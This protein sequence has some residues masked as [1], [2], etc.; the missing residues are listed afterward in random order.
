MRRNNAKSMLRVGIAALALAA[1]ASCGSVK[2]K[3]ASSDYN[4]ALLSFSDG[5]TVEHNTLSDIY[6]AIVTEGDTNSEKVLN[7]VLYLYSKSLYGPYFDETASDGTTVKGIKSIADAYL[8]NSAATSDIDAFASAYDVYQPTDDKLTTDN[9]TLAA[10]ARTNVISF[11]NEVTFRINTVF[12]GYVTDTNYQER[13]QFQEKK[14]YD[15]QV[16]NYYVLGSQYK[17]DYVQVDGSFRLTGEA[18]ADNVLMQR[19]FADLFGTY[20]DYIAINVLPDIYRNELT[21]QYLYSQNFGTLRMTSARKVDYIEL[22]NNGDYS[23]AVPNLMQ[24][25][26]KEVIVP[27]K[28]KDFG[29]PFLNALYKGTAESYI[30]GLT[31]VTAKAEAQTLANAIY[32]DA[33]WT[34]T[35]ATV[36]GVTYNTY[37]QSSLGTIVASYNKLTDSRF[38]DDATVRSNFTNSGAYS[39][40][41]GFYVQYQAL[42]AKDATKNGWF[43]AGGLSSLPSSLSDRAFLV[44]VANEVD[45]VTDDDIHKLQYGWYVGGSYYLTPATYPSGSA[46][47]YLVNDGTNYFLVRVDEAVKAAKITAPA[48]SGSNAL[49]YDLTKGYGYAQSIARKMA[50]ALSSSDTWKK[51]AK[52]YY[53]DQIALIYHDSY[54]YDDFEKT[55]PERFD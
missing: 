29:F 32:A 10:E 48:T 39:V 23:D 55:L 13:S 7:N 4:A 33:G 27:G 14:F 54:V 51:A 15:A 8:A 45:S 40:E 19:Y 21:A 18:V 1:L 25:Y 22:A 11:Y 49:Y 44:Q 50:Y 43:T 16:K 47:P 42:L 35:S 38:T 20:G 41:T 17:S 52:T 26:C 6:D 5:S 31:D 24:A 2:A 12:Y 30:N 36:N 9:A 34:A 53:V 46:Y 37:I 3:P 28:V